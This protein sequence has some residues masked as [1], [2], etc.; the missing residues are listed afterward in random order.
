MKFRSIKLIFIGLATALLLGGCSNWTIFDQV[1]ND[2]WLTLSSGS[3]I[4]QTFVADYDGLQAVQLLLAPETS[5]NGQLVFH[6]RS[7]PNSTVDLAISKI[8][9]QEITENRYY[10]F[11]FADKTHSSNQYYFA[12]L[13]IIG[14][15]SIR[16]GAGPA[17]SY[18]DGAA[19]LGQTPLDAQLTFTLAYNR[20]LAIMGILQEMIS[21]MGYVFIGITLFTIPGWALLSLL[22]SG[23][24]E[25]YY[26]VKL[27]LSVGVSLTIYILFMLYTFLIH[28]QLGVWYALLPLIIGL[29]IIILRNWRLAIRII[30]RQTK[31]SLTEKANVYSPIWPDLVL[32]IILA[33]T[34][35]ARLW[36]MRGLEA[37]MW[38]DSVQH[39]EIVQLMINQQGLFN[40][41]MPYAPY[42]TF[43]MHFGF[44]LAATLFA[45]MT[46][47]SSTQAV[48]FTGQIL[49][50]LA[51]FVLYPLAI[52]F[53]KGNRWAGVITVLGVG[54]LSPMPAYYINWG[55]YAQLAGQVILPVCL[56]MIWDSL[57][58]VSV[59]RQAHWWVRLPWLKI[60]FTGMTL[61]A[62]VLSQF[63]MPYFFI[64][65]LIT[66]FFGW[67][68]SQSRKNVSTFLHSGLVLTL[69]GVIGIVLF[70][71][72]GMRVL[73]SNLM[74]ILSLSSEKSILVDAIKQNYV[75]WRDILFYVPVGL[76]ILAF[77]G[78]VWA[79][80]KKDWLTASI[81]FWIAAMSLIY[82]FMVL[83]IPGTQF[84]QPFAVQIALYIP[85]GLL[86]GYIMGDLAVYMLQR[87]S[88][89]LIVMCILISLSFFGAWRQRNITQPSDYAM[90]TRPDIRAMQWIRDETPVQAR[91]LVEG[92]QA[93]WKTNIVGADAGWWI[94]ILTG[95]ENT[96]PPQYA[97]T[98]EVP[99]AKEY[100]QGLVN[101]ISQLSQI[102]LYTDEGVNLL[103]NYGITH[104]Y[105]GQEQGGVGNY[106]EPLFTSADLEQS[107]D[108]KLVYQKDR[109]FIYAL[110][111]DACDK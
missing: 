80:I 51:A 62:M 74:T 103:C 73:Q 60:I 2:Q 45:W 12:Y 105:I 21:W 4:G 46:G 36:D 63:R 54:L 90:V 47:M 33:L 13:Q 69:I 22:W 109:V 14:E 84:L 37:P 101:L 11:D 8:P 71:P 89:G 77:F 19:Y 38:G 18:E 100:S 20:S 5:G 97:I 6:L 52:R 87:R 3:L 65:F 83:R 31:L 79:I 26:F 86:F 41:W 32:V 75:L 40:S 17:E 76:I 10:R 43:S 50:T 58:S 56:W 25:L 16:I 67:Y 110:N 81:G 24:G 68:L 35:M 72:W 44:P 15:G 23:W 7:D 108:L 98:D 34:F 85:I 29:T 111:E 59:N 39:T 28:I 82:I 27:A 96:M 106:G 94:P 99:I 91:F 104:V 1:A 30:T 48:L 61:T 95:R 64:A 78:F 102:K 55:R 57:E 88:G 92:F 66:W 70:I 9:L 49:I 93:T 42:A 107:D 53:A